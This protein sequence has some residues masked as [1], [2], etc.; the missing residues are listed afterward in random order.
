MEQFKQV[1]SRPL[2]APW[3]EVAPIVEFSPIK[4]KFL[5][6][7]LTKTSVARHHSPDLPV[8]GRAH[9]VRDR[10]EAQ[11]CLGATSDSDDPGLAGSDQDAE[12]EDSSFNE[13]NHHWN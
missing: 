1:E 9:R 6:R 8:L 4:T 3:R 12:E 11:P 2:N 7:S 13:P 10:A 5:P